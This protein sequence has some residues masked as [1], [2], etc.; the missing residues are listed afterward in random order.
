M[1]DRGSQVEDTNNMKGVLIMKHISH[2]MLQCVLL[3]CGCVLFACV[4]AA[5]TVVRSFDGDSGPGLTECQA[6]NTWCGRQSETN[7]AANGKQVV[8]G[9]PGSPPGRLPAGYVAERAGL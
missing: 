1:S 6:G 4:S 8:Q 3:A 9:L 5:Q 7:V 2:C